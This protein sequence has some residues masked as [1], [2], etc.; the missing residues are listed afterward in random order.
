MIVNSHAQLGTHDP[1]EKCPVF[2][3]EHFTLRLVQEEDAEDLLA[4]YADLSTWVFYNTDMCK[5]I[6]SSRYPTLEEMKACIRFWLDEYENKVYIRFSVLEKATGKAIGTIEAFDKVGKDPNQVLEIVQ[7]GAVLHMDLARPFETPEYLSELLAL[8]DRHFFAVFGVTSLLTRV[9]PTAENRLSAVRSAGYT[10]F[11][12]EQ[13]RE[14]Y[15]VH[16]KG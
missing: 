2:E 1:Y 10:P 15:W 7:N 6:F 3:T 13:G 16:S 12:W 5:R 4:C 9:L 11:E 8:A 14:Y